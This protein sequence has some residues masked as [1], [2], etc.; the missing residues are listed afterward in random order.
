MA[1]VLDGVRVLDFGR[2]VA[3]PVCAALLGDLGADV[4]RVERVDGAEDRGIV[5]LAGDRDGG[6]LFL[7]AN[8]GKRGMTLN[9]MRQ[10]G[11]E[12]LRRL[13]ATADVVVA[14]LPDRAL[15]AMG[16]DAAA[17]HAVRPDAVLVTTDAF[18][19]GP[20]E[21]RLGFDGVGQVM[22]GAAHLSGPP[23]GPAKAAALWVD[24]G[25]AAL[26][27][28][29]ALAGLLQRERTGAGD[30][31]RTALLH[32]ALTVMGSSLTEESVTAPGRVGSDNRA[33]T[34]GPADIVATRDGHVIVQVVGDP[35][36]GRFATMVG[37]PELVDDPRFVDDAERGRH[38]DELCDV[39]A[40]FCGE[41]STAEVLEAFVA[42]GLA[43]AP[44][45]APSEVLDHEHV[46]AS[47]MLATVPYPGVAP[48]PVVPT[49]PV[50][51]AS[52]GDVTPRRA[53]LLGEHTDELLAELGYAPHEVAALHA[54]RVV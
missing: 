37:R 24:Y 13:L 25:T 7:Q 33:Q 30:H 14:N 5:P 6:A 48:D 39:A 34:V 51:F 49:A 50:R 36:F 31:V 26:A 40:A 3:G 12:V 2:Y 43:S 32:T 23:D 15:A 41:R 20:W 1:G 18:G 54:A 16:L 19:P 44:V 21:G 42:A 47:G 11:A 4:V 9:P 27:A 22:S 46:T 38:R 35:M 45:L 29:G 17:V 10:E 8:R 53:P 28:V 52:V